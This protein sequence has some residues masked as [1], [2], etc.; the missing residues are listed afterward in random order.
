MKF[1]FKKLFE[2]SLRVFLTSKEFLSIASEKEKWYGTQYKQEY[3]SEELIK[4]Y[5][6]CEINCELYLPIPNEFIPTDFQLFS[7]EKN[8]PRPQIPTK[9]KVKSYSLDFNLKIRFFSKKRKMNI[10]VFIM[11]MIHFIDFLK[12][13]FILNFESK[14]NISVCFLCYFLTFSPL[15]YVDPIHSNLTTLYVELINDSLTEFVYPAQLGGL[16]YELYDCND[17]IQVF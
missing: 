15:V 2:C 1:I 5:E 14:R 4:Q 8:L 17:S 12:L 11:L 7:K 9:V 10:I 13:I 16:D 3:L 6:T